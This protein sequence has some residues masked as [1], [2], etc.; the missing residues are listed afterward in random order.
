MAE[1]LST[2]AN[3]GGPMKRP[4]K[5]PWWNPVKYFEVRKR[6]PIEQRS[7]TKI[8]SL[9]AI[10]LFAFTMWAV[11]NEVMTRRPW[12]DIQ[13]D[14]I[15]FK[16]TRLKLEIKKERNKIDPAVRKQVNGELKAAKKATQAKPYLENLDRLDD[17][18]TKIV[19]AQRDYTFTKSNAD[20]QYY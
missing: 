18:D 2:G 12:K 7:Y 16:T 19:K 1:Q 14:F 20:E 4:E 15:E 9:L 6:V 13:A 17:L 3:A 5:A 8:Y 10:A 11:L